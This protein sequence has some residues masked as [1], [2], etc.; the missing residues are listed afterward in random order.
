LTTPSAGAEHAQDH[1]EPLV[2]HERPRSGRVLH[3]GVP[4]LGDHA[5]TYYPDG[6]PRPGAVLTVTFLL[7]GQEMTAVNGGPQFTFDE[8]ISLAINCADQAE[9]DR[10]WEILTGDGGEESQCGWLKDK[11]GLSWQVVP[12]G[13]EKLYTSSDKAAVQRALNKMYTMKKLD[14]AA[15]QAAFDDRE[16]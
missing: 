12:E 9:V 3:V 1:A 14:L 15:L 2:R 8:A 5:I 6:A 10:Y 13:W 7:D 4:E 16:D 11:F